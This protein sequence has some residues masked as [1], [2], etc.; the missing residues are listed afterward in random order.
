MFRRVWNSKDMVSKLLGIFFI[1]ASLLIYGL[2][3][4]GGKI[5]SKVTWIPN[6]VLFGV[7]FIM[8]TL[9]ACKGHLTN[10]NDNF[11]SKRE[12]I[13]LGVVSILVFLVQAIVSY[14]II[15]RTSW[16][17]AAVWY[18][19]HWT[20]LGDPE[21]IMQMSEYFSLCP[22]NLF[23][24]FIFSAILKLNILLGNPISNGGLL[25]VLVQCALMNLTGVLLHLCAR[26]LM[27]R[28]LAWGA[29]IFYIVLI[30]I[31][32]WMVLPYSDGMGVIFPVLFL[33]LYFKTKESASFWRYALC[34]IMFLCGA[35]AFYIKPY[36]II[37]IIAVALIELIELIKNRK[38]GKIKSEPAI[39]GGMVIT[40]IIALIIGGF[41][42]STANDSLGFE[43][44]KEMNMDFRHYMMIG[45]NVDSWGGYNDAD[46]E[47]V[48]Q[49]DNK[50]QRNEAELQITW[51]RLK[52][53][54]IPG[55]AELLLHKMSKDY[56]DG[57]FGW[58]TYDSFYTEIYDSKG[59]F[60]CEP[61]RSWFYGI[62]TAYPY[63]ALIRQLLW[64]FILAFAPLAVFTQK[65]FTTVEKV[66]L[67]TV[68]G[69]TLYLGIFESHARYLFTFAPIYILLAAMGLKRL[70]EGLNNS[71]ME[72]GNE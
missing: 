44:N 52:N 58:G 28:K 41:F 48:K 17:V 4:F 65:N 38:K 57:T 31:S 12:Y 40:A 42:I 66:L 35:I 7:A 36:T 19:A 64:I 24:V 16:D 26:R 69:Y 72:K 62:G 9:L 70:A 27:G 45:V 33:Y 15:F 14:N 22:N 23:L 18:G 8:G 61:L 54:G 67:L 49:Y 29:Y 56:L 55:Y 71:G 51:E 21:G 10:H 39:I 37:V 50:Q 63:N 34:F 2:L 53:M 13:S 68:L 30:A 60:L 5:S 46:L 59:N 11:R 32:G 43:I 25:L 6:Y 3:L 47:F 20:A 1:I